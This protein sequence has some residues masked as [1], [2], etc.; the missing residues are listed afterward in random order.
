[1]RASAALFKMFAADVILNAFL[2]NRWEAYPLRETSSRY[3]SPQVTY[4][5]LKAGLF[6]S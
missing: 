2:R 4:K 3:I 1:M 6:L 5:F